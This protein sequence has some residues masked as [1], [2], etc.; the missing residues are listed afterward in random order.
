MSE[1]TQSQANPQ[2]P[3]YPAPRPFT[4]QGSYRETTQSTELNELFA[5]MSKAQGAMKEAAKTQQNKYFESNYADYHDI[6]AVAQ[7]PLADNELCIIHTPCEDDGRAGMET[8]LGHSSGQWM[9]TKLLLPVPM[10]K[11]GTRLTTQYVAIT[12]YAKRIIMQSMCNIAADEDNDLQG[13]EHPTADK[14]TIDEFQSR[15]SALGDTPA[16]QKQ[17]LSRFNKSFGIDKLE[18]LLASQ[19]DEAHSALQE[20]EIGL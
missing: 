17:L 5:A 15:I 9:K 8:W 20:K 3:E 12:S 19:V 10:S 2:T 13:V 4:P 6:W 16:K 11:D 14:K 1:R 7:K 18:D